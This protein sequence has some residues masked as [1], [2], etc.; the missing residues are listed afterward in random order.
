MS[1][2]VYWGFLLGTKMPRPWGETDGSGAL[3]GRPGPFF[4]VFDFLKGGNPS[5]STDDEQ[6]MRQEI[7]IWPRC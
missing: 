2:D 1:P 5:H 4:A 3:P 6:G 7:R